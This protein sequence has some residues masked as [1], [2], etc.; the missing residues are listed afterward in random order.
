MKSLSLSFEIS[1]CS[2]SSV[3]YLKGLKLMPKFVTKS[4]KCSSSCNFVLGKHCG[5]N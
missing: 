2:S 5:G 4:A 3:K 1:H